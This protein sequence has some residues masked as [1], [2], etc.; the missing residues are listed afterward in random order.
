MTALALD[1]AGAGLFAVR[2]WWVAAA[3]SLAVGLLAIALQTLDPRELAGVNIW[4][5]PAK[6]GFSLALHMATLA[7]IARLMSVGP[8]ASTLIAL[9]AA[10]SVAAAAV[11]MVWIIRQAGLAQQSHFNVS[12]SFH[13]AMY[14]VMAVGAV[15]IIGAAGVVGALVAVDE[16]WSH[17]EVLRWGIASGLMVGTALTLFT[18]FSIGAAMSPYVGPEIAETARMPITGWSLS[19]GDLRVS[20]FLATHMLQIV[21][22]AA[23]AFDRV[24]DPQRA[25]IAMWVIALGWSAVTTGA[26]AQAKAG[27]PIGWTSV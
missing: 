15:L 18:A 13:A 9:A 17:G 14:Q 6:F 2:L 7:L 20:H 26:W 21:P 16:G 12:T 23:L 8:A 25:M 11:E 10:L 1:P 24:L 4:V 27:I 5:K 19:R 22:L 3:A